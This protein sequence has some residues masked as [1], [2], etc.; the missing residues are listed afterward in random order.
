M[1]HLVPCEGCQ[2]HVRSDEGRCPFCGATVRGDSPAPVLPD[3]PLSR[4]AL[5]VFAST[6]ALGSACQSTSDQGPAARPQPDPTAQ[7]PLP[8][9]AETPSPPPAADAG[10]SQAEIPQ[11]PPTA[12]YGAPPRPMDDTDAG[13]PGPTS[14]P[15]PTPTPNPRP[16]PRR[17]GTIQVRYGAPPPPA[18]AEW[19]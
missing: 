10:P 2:R 7:G 5:F 13:A 16:R 1:R 15:D 11:V 12:V 8:G 3:R 14:T 6:V 9:P 4:A 19:L 18:D 17:P